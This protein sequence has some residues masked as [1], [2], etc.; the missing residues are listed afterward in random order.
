MVRIVFFFILTA[1]AV[2]AA[3]TLSDYPGVV[4]V[5]W[6]GRIIELPI[7]IGIAGIIAVA[8]LGAV[9]F[10]LFRALWRTPGAIG[11][12]LDKRRTNKGYQA[13]SSGMV[14]VAAGDADEARRHANK[15]HRLL[16]R[17]P[18]T[19]LLSAQAAQL[20]GNEKAAQ[21]YFEAML[22]DPQTEFLGVRG[23]LTLAAKEGKRPKVLNLAKR[24]LALKPESPWAQTTAFEAQVN[25]H[26]WEEAQT[27]LQRAV[28]KKVVEKA[29]SNKLKAALLVER[30]RAVLTDGDLD[31]ALRLAGQAR[32]A[33]PASR[34]AA[35]CL[36]RRQLEAGKERAAKST[37]EK[38]WSTMPSGQLAMLYA[39]I[40]PADEKPEQLVTRMKRLARSN[41]D[42]VES[43]LAVASAQIGTGEYDAA[44]EA[45]LRVDTV[46]PSQRVYRLLAHLDRE[47]GNPQLVD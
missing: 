5:E 22:D 12:H 20:N 26:L 25:S 44:R 21:N 41:P 27:T 14:A 35:L 11:Q 9:A 3:L 23:L 19:R 28:A 4:R 31:E 32:R 47:S 15:A 40:G 17:Q 29:D 42:H 13:L 33:D 8:L 38:A 45:L 36:A 46:E 16:S 10:W 24:A 6:L 30:S 1:A 18:L 43:L 39:D 2:F 37:I 34:A 7:G